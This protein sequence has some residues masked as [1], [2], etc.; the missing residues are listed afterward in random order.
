M[1]ILITNYTL[2]TRS[3]T[4]TYVRD[5]ALGLLARG[6]SP[7]VYSPHD[8]PIARELRALTIPV[9][10]DL[11]KIS[12]SVDVIH[13]HHRH[14]TLTAL[15]HFPGVP[16][17]FFV[18][19]WHAWQDEP[20]SFPRI[21]RYVAVDETRRD[22]LILEN[23]IDPEL[24]RV[25]PNGVDVQRFRPRAP[26]PAQPKRAVVFSNYIKDESELDD[27]R[28]ACHTAGMSLDAVGAGLGSGT[29]EPERL[30]A[31]YDL[32][33]ALGR[34]ALEAMAMGCGVVIWGREGLGGFVHP[35]NFSRLQDHNFGRRAL[36]P[37]SPQELE[38]EIRRFT[39]QEARSIQTLVRSTLPNS[40]LIERHLDIYRE[41]IDAAAQRAWDPAEELRSAAAYIKDCVPGPQMNAIQARAAQRSARLRNRLVDTGCVALA[42]LVIAFG[43]R[44]EL[45]ALAQSAFGVSISTIAVCLLLCLGL[46][47]LRMQLRGSLSNIRLEQQH[48]LSNSTAP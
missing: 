48:R 47:L 38:T 13:G 7:I 35:G 41:I 5:L 28:L 44:V 4:E 33:F 36:R 14:E 40:E 43:V 20:P 37:A 18:H 9:V 15:L 24:V 6:H 32:V 29:S 21:L 39:P 10:D 27:L 26:L 16:A 8:G 3:G 12:G 22:R 17:V 11:A 45:M 1:K 25:I 2:A 34:S 30:L 23:G 19:D 42:L 46:Y 31:Q